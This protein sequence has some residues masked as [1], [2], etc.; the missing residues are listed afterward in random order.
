MI[1]AKIKE[2]AVERSASDLERNG[3]QGNVRR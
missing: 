2:V 3:K 1:W